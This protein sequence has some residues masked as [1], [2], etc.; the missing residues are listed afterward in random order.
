MIL[1]LGETLKEI[2]FQEIFTERAGVVVVIRSEEAGNL[3]EKID[4]QYEGDIGLY[5]IGFNKVE[6]QQ[7]CIVG[8][9]YIPKLMDISEERYRMQFFINEKFIVIV[10][11]GDFTRELIDRIIAK[12]SHQGETKSM[13]LYNL[14]SEFMSRDLEVLGQYEKM[15]MRIEENIMEEKTEDY[16]S[17]LMP[18]RKKLLTLRGYY[19]EISDMGKELEDNEI[20]LFSKKEL[21]HFGII[22]D[23]A[24][25]LMGKTE[26]LLEYASQVKD[27][28]Q[29]QADSRQNSNMQF[30][31][32]IST[33]F[34]PLTLITGWYGMNFKN[35]PELEKG[36]PGVLVLSVIVVII[37]IVVFKLKKIF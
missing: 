26:H 32:I 16:Q 11:D 36:Y 8:S 12:K 7:N 27:A 1:E 24:E 9:L 15:L 6:T 5:A 28:Y 34:F 19:N 13:F 31:T 23:R 33:I 17:E 4:L 25:R 29:T 22:R 35:M 18:I 21:R 10:D 3:L 14:F 2:S 20:D 30:L 37:C